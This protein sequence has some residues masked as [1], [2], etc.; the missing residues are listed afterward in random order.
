MN[1]E[2]K[3]IMG[4]ELSVPYEKSPSTNVDYIHSRNENTLLPKDKNDRLVCVTYFVLWSLL[5]RVSKALDMSLLQ[6][7]MAYNELVE[8]GRV[9][10][11]QIVSHESVR[12]FG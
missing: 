11:T 7:T 6:D 1:A 4:S 10:G 5:T 12:G 8:D 2:R 9:R 3:T